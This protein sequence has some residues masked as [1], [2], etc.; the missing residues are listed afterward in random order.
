MGVDVAVGVSFGVVAGNDIGIGEV[1]VSGG[2]ANGLDGE[3][4][5]IIGFELHATHNH[6][7]IINKPCR[8]NHLV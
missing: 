4:V 6:T 3:V 5:R 1:A 2:E 8:I 7:K